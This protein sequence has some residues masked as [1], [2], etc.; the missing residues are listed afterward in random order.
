MKRKIM[1]LCGIMVIVIIVLFF[2]RPSAVNESCDWCGKRPSVAF[3]VGD[4][5]KSYVCK[6][7]RRN[8]AWCDNKAK[9]HYENAAGMMV[10]VCDDCYKD[11]NE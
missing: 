4:G 1:L 10:F 3:K 7:C 2:K 8:C 11:L 9:K 5:S 6:D